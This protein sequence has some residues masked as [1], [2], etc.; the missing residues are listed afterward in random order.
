VL[1]DVGS[2]V[3]TVIRAG[4]SKGT[5]SVNYSTADGTATAGSDYTA[6]SGTLLFAD[7]ETTKTISIPIVN[8]GVSEPD[9]IVQLALTGVT[10]LDELGNPAIA[11][12][13]IRDNGTP[14]V[15][16]A[17]T[18][19]SPE[20]NSGTTNV[21]VIVSLSAQTGRTITVDYDTVAGSA[22]SGVDFVAT[23]GS[24][25]FAPAVT[26]QDVTVSIIG[27]TI[28]ESNE[29][30]HVVLSNPVN[31]SIG[32]SGTVRIINDDLFTITSVIAP[33]GRS[34][35]GQQIRLIG[36]FSSLSTVR[37]G[38]LNAD[39]FYTNGST[40]TTSITVT[41]PPHAV[42]AVSI[43]LTSTGGSTFVK[44]N[45]FAYLPTTF[46]DNDLVAGVT[47]AK[48]QHILELRQAVNALRMVA[49]IGSA[50]W[51]DLGLFPQATTIKAVHIVELRTYLE[52][53]AARLGY[54]AGT[55]TDPT[56]S[57]G[58]VI[59]RIHIEE[60]RQRIRTIAG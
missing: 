52:D 15:L 56:L 51:T 19:D 8:D 59:K 38:G 13:M 47:T 24:L 29:T 2:A 25:T 11:T 27:D 58:F 12:M 4:G 42:G 39:W 26:R 1:E 33:A 50:P 43:A 41:T 40:D 17:N 55:Y 49:G 16:T 45:A 48:A 31:A 34:S 3:I 21:D 32:S 44:N 20:G 37:V 18:V 35:G 23:S 46:T 57:T 36:A 6:T 22:I 30:F 14:L 10:D 53:A 54:P 7:G 5:L 60:L 28:S 9:E